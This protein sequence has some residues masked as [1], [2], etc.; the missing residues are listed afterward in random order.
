[1]RN[2]VEEK[3]KGLFSLLFFKVWPNLELV[4]KVYFFLNYSISNPLCPKCPF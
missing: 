1:M 3:N 4:F 2:I